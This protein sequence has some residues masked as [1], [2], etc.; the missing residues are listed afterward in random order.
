M[1]GQTGQV[2]GGYKVKE[3]HIFRYIDCGQDYY[4]TGVRNESENYGW[5]PRS[6][7]EL[8]TTVSRSDVD[9]FDYPY[10]NVSGARKIILSGETLCGPN[11]DSSDRSN[12]VWYFGSNAGLD[13]NPI[14]NGDSPTPISGS[15]VSSEGSSVISDKEGKLLFYT[16]GE[17]VYTSGDT[18]MVNGSGLYGNT[19]ATQSS[20]IIPKPNSTKYYIFNT[21]YDGATNGFLYSVVD[22]SLQSGNGQVQS[23]NISLIS[24]NG[25]EKVTGAKH[26]NGSDYW[27]ITHTSGDSKFYSYKVSSDGLS[28]PVISDIGSVNNTIRG[29]LKVSPNS[30]KII[31]ALYDEDIIDIFDFTS[32]AGTLT[33]L[34]T[35]T[36]FTFDNGPY[37]V[38]FSSDSSKFYI[39]DG[40]MGKIYQFDLSYS[41]TTDMVDNYIT[42]ANISGNTIGA[43]QMG[44]DGK[45]YIGD[46][47]SDTLHIIHYPN[48]LGVE[49]NFEKDSIELF[50]GT[51][52][53]WGLPNM[54][55][56]NILSCDRYIYIRE[57]ESSN[58]N[59]EFTINDV[60]GV[61][62]DKELN[63]YSEVY[64]Y[65]N[66]LGVFDTTPLLTS[67]AI[68]FNQFSASTTT[69]IPLNNIGEGEF[70]IKGYYA[71]PIQT[72]VGKQLDFRYDTITNN[73]VG[74]EF[75]IYDKRYDW[76]FLNM[77]KADKPTFINNNLSA[78][79]VAGQL[80]VSS[81]LTTSGITGYSYNGIGEPIVS[82]NGS[83]LSKLNN[84]YLF[85][86]VS[87]DFLFEVLDNQVVTYAYGSNS[88]TSSIY[89]DS[90]VVGSI[91]SGPTNTQTDS[92]QI[93]L[94]NTQNKYEYYLDS[95]SN[96][97]VIITV[98]GSTLTKG[99][100]YYV[101]VT[102]PKRVIFEITINSGDIIQAFYTPKTGF[103]GEINT[104][105]L[106]IGW[107]I[108][109]PPVVGQ[110]G[111]FNVQMADTNDKDFET[112][113]YSASTDYVIGKTS[114]FVNLRISGGTIGDKF[115]YRVINEKSY[116]PISGET[117]TSTTI[118]ESVPIE[119]TT[120]SVNSY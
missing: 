40:A 36:G 31:N 48:G 91:N 16:D 83:V 115:L 7:T 82:Y 84:D 12:Y 114:Y 8:F 117:I 76:Y 55:N 93:F 26:S 71:P 3:N 61:V 79:V 92:D 54:I 50:S 75:G 22:M 4:E 119:L 20:I 49:C 85:N 109:N 72:L 56:D 43:L 81:F 106:Q 116:K 53:E 118:S 60:T 86:G 39:S 21:N 47:D 89:V 97:G 113:L 46:K 62:Q 74:N 14:E 6:N 96:G 37:G 100:E 112:I 30:S 107:I 35:I 65:N 25:T 19:G 42:V 103:V 98:N 111:I 5:Q 2:V 66:S 18:I 87:I 58:F 90:L 24:K 120:N 101:S 88:V 59:F 13:F 33:N 1:S 45:I 29:Y 77:Y 38:E 99:V 80:T 70:L 94:N 68:T 52:S 63:F 11:S 27:A 51:T 78:G 10:F 102:N 34:L 15:V 41:S 9:A 69:N 95:E 23:K 57:S 64:K 17:T 28:T 105:T 73:K 108:N 110:N 44:P 104:N 32:S 67:S